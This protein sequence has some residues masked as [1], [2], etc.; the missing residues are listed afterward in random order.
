MSLFYA[1]MYLYLYILSLYICFYI[2]ICIN[3]ST[4]AGNFCE[5]VETHLQDHEDSLL[6]INLLNMQSTSNET[7]TAQLLLSLTRKMDG[8]C[9]DRTTQQ[10]EVVNQLSQFIS[11]LH[12]NT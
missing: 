8:E 9:T 5:L 12:N 11:S 4:S 10:A 6:E 2:H 3:I 1:L 7:E